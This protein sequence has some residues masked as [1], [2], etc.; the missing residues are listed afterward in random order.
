M[1]K[2]TAIIIIIT[3][4][5]FVNYFI[6]VKVNGCHPFTIHP[7]ETSWTL[8]TGLLFVAACSFTFIGIIALI[9]KIKRNEKKN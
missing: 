2:R 7:T 8:I 9:D 3:E 5:I 6:F 4:L 1:K